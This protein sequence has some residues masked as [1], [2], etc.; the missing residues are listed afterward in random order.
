MTEIDESIMPSDNDLSESMLSAQKEAE[1]YVENADSKVE[2][3]NPED[4]ALLAAPK[5]LH[6]GQSELQHQTQ[7]LK[8][9][10]QQLDLLLL[11]A[12]SY[13]HFIL[14]NQKRSKISTT[15]KVPTEILTSSTSDAIDVKGKRK[16]TPAKGGSGKKTKGKSAR[17]EKED[18]TS[19]EAQLEAYD[20]VAA[21]AAAGGFCQPNTLVGGTLM[22]YQLEGLQW[23][24]SLWENGLSGILAD[25]MGL[26]KTIQIIS[27]IA[28][29]RNQ[30]TAGPFI[31]AGPLA[32]LP[33]WMN[34]FKKWL[35]SCP[36]VLY[37]GSKPEREA[38]RMKH[39][40]VKEEKSMT[41]PVVI[42]SFEILMID[43]P[44]L[45]KYLWQYIILDEG[46]RIKNRNCKLVK[47]LKSFRSV[48]RLL[49]TGTPIQNT[50][51]ELWSLLNFCSPQI[52][53][54]LEVSVLPCILF[55]TNHLFS[56]CLTSFCTYAI[57]GGQYGNRFCNSLRCC[58]LYK[59]KH[60]HHNHINRSFKVGSVSEI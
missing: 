2:I 22:P 48:S 58:N 41:F 19:A 37:H 42:T 5:L 6:L 44:F 43:R 52:F 4:I 49:L 32:T 30:N 16:A 14:E 45:E 15:T 55:S 46:H 12:E 59:I 24:L 26:G 11:K 20:S 23:L 21:T 33:N 1:E 10:G 39:M 56:C 9:R 51:E 25:E 18:N 40:S 27:L 8:A 57:L 47:E 36:V 28:H 3:L 54:D 34:E 7:G 38:I 60:H 35:P 13:S 53:D 31:V 50:L 17:Q 29:L